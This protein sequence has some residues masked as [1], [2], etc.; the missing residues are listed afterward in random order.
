MVDEMYNDF[1]AR[2]GGSAVLHL[3]IAQHHRVY[4]KNQHMEVIHLC[5]AE[6]R[7]GVAC[8]SSSVCADPLSRS[9]VQPAATLAF[10][11]GCPFLVLSNLKRSALV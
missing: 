1:L 7:A 2:M 4:H 3:F 8:S 11:R 5:A 10:S 6:V 9:C